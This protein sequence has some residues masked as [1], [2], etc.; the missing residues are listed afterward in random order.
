MAYTMMDRR[1]D[2]A[3]HYTFERT[4]APDFTERKVHPNTYLVRRNAFWQVNG[5]D[6]DLT[7][8]GG[9]GYGGDNQF[10]RQLKVIVPEVHLEDVLLIGFGRRH[11]EGEPIIPDAD[12]DLDRAAWSERYQKALHK[13]KKSGDLRSRDPIRTEYVRIL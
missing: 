10:M 6:L 12:T 7:P 8:I 11:R 1:L 9:G 2:S 4:F 3:C 13:K 5:Y